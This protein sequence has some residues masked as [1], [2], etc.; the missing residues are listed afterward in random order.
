M[1]SYLT[2]RSS[3]TTFVGLLD[4][5]TGNRTEYLKS[6]PLVFGENSI[7]P[8]GKWIVFAA[9]RDTRDFTVYA[10]PF[11][12]SQPPVQSQWVEIV[13]SPQTNPS[14]A[15]SPDGN[16]LYFSSERDGYTCLWALRLDPA[17]KHPRGPLFAVRHFHAPSQT[18]A[19]PS[20]HYPLALAPDKIIVSLAERAGGI[21]IM[22]LPD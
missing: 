13:R 5:S 19:A 17:T 9:H 20:F 12:V 1:G 11:S 3:P 14:A 8:D 4:V 2:Y 10:A 18:M 21:W 22:Q 15:W 7:S 6:S 16:L